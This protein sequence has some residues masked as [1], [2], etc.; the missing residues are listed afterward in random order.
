MNNITPR[1]NG[2]QRPWHGLQL[3]STS[4]AVMKLI[5]FWTMQYP[6]FIDSSF[7]VSLDELSDQHLRFFRMEY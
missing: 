6:A 2:F 1:T 5:F 7:K 4:V 3:L